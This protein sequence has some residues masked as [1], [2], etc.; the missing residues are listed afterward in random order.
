MG[1]TKSKK[2]NRRIT[3]LRSASGSTP[4]QSFD[5]PLA[6]AA[7]A[8]LRRQLELFL[9]RNSLAQRLADRMLAETGTDFFEW[10]DHLTM[11]SDQEPAL[12]ETG[13][14]PEKDVE[15]PP[16]QT[17]Y[18]HPRAT[19]PRVLVGGDS[20]VLA[21]RPEY[22]AD[23]IAQH[24]LQ[25][26]PEGAPYSRFRRG[27]VSEENGTRL[28]AVERNAYRGFVSVPLHP[29]ELES[30]IKTRELLETRPRLFPEDAEGFKV[31]HALL[32]RVLRLVDRDLACK[33][34]FEAERKYWQS[35]NYA[36]RTQK[37]RQDRLGLG[38]GNHDHHTFR[39]SRQ[40]FVDV[41]EFLLKL[42]FQKR[43]RYYAGSEAGW[44]AQILE[45][46]LAGIVVFADVDLM[47]QE[48]QL[49]FS[50]TRLS[51]A[52]RLGT[53]GLWVGL[54]G[55]SFLEAGMHH[56]E[57]RFDF[58]QLQEQ[59]KDCGIH[60]MKPFS[61][62]DF[63]RQAFTEGER[64]PVRRQCAERLLSL[65]L[66]TAEQFEKF[67]SQGAI[68]SHLENLQR[69]GGFKGFNQKS[70]SVIISATDPRKQHFPPAPV[71]A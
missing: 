58:S 13:F 15:T 4:E 7:E 68:G 49:D 25:G 45:Q 54:H 26:E 16:G 57:A 5:W 12:R 37:L 21:L 3:A 33:L 8:L 28:E 63:L 42:G 19:L 14:V 55:E 6:N 18:H 20:P 50:S 27:L 35:R 9:S 47:P 64:W 48:T 46:P 67:L 38:W 29:G 51:P 17:A 1:P 11:P 62:F 52:P 44:G 70:V 65:G 61:D 31:A 36:A 10:I 22:L 32:E 69:H 41:I 2:P 34:F 43:E 59:L 56:L 30:I 24:N 71:A 39:C 53:V 66:I 60:T 23:F 40:H